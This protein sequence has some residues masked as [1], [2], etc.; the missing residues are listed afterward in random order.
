MLG[1]LLLEDVW[2]MHMAR[3]RTASRRQP[4]ADSAGAA[5][6]AVAISLRASRRFM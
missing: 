2:D 1:I 5:A 6:P 3:S 4:A